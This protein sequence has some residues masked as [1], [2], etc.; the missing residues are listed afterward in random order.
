MK[1]PVVKSYLIDFENLPVNQYNYVAVSMPQPAVGSRSVWWV[2]HG[3]EH[4]IK[5]LWAAH[6]IAKPARNGRGG[7]NQSPLYPQRGGGRTSNVFTPMCAG[8][9]FQ[10]PTHCGACPNRN[11]TWDPLDPNETQSFYF[12]EILKL[13]Q[14]RPFLVGP[15]W[16]PSG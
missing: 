9:G 7:L 2:A 12:N 15:T 11:A 14:W 8:L 4:N 16:A 3:G 6:S 1:F 5:Q 10:K 13:M